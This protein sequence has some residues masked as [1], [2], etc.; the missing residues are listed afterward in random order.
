MDGFV[1][2]L[3]RENGESKLLKRTSG[4]QSIWMD[5]DL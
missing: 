5:D 4:R 1:A 3:A 2:K